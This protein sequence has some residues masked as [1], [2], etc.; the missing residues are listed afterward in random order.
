MIWKSAAKISNDNGCNK[1]DQEFR[2]ELKTLQ[3]IS[4]DMRIDDSF[5][6]L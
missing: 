5:E 6:R 1:R 3:E 2:C 4:D